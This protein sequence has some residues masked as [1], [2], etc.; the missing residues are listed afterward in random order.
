M[1]RN[2][3]IIAFAAFTGT[4]FAL[5]DTPANRSEEAE[6]YIAATPPQELFADIAVN[7]AK[8]MPEG[9]RKQFIDLMTKNLDIAAVTDAMKESMVK[10]FTA[11][12]LKALADFYNSPVGKSA[13][14][15]MG[16]YMADLMP[17]MQTEIQKA[18]TKAQAAP[19]AD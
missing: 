6:R 13:M 16:P 3:W 18:M 8:A 10:T 9:Q 17:V 14:K 19:G 11:D 15:K 4:C 2:L 12:E 7:M 1:K 5:E